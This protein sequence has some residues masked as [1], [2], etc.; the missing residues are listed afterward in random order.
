MDKGIRLKAL[1]RRCRARVEL[2]D[3]DA[4]MDDA[5][6]VKGESE[7]AWVGLG[8]VVK[9]CAEMKQAHAARQRAV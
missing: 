1:V 6:G 8:D 4:A 9:R 7:E 2:G 3:W 5:R